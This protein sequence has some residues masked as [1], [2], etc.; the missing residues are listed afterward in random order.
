MDK[1]QEWIIGK[2]KGLAGVDE[3]IDVVW[4]YGSGDNKVS[5]YDFA[6]AFIQFPEDDWDKRLQLELVAQ[7]GAGTFSMSLEKI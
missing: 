6:I 7:F 3:N 2:V 1:N 4:L 5:D